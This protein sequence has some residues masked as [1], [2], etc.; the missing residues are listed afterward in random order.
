MSA[1]TLAANYDTERQDGR[2]LRYK[3]AA[4]KTIYKGAMLGLSSGLAQ[5]FADGSGEPFIGVAYEYAKSGA[6]DTIY[7][8]V[9]KDGVHTFTWYDDD[10]IA[11]GDIG[12]E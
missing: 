2:L 1:G 3:L 9:E 4:S 12:S 5:P 6:S 11:A 7:C 8:R 10:A